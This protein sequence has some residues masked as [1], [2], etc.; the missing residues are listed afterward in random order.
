MDNGINS[1]KWMSIVVGILITVLF[2]WSFLVSESPLDLLYLSIGLLAIIWGFHIENGKFNETTTYFAAMFCVNAFQWLILI[3]VLFISRVYV[4]ND[5][6]TLIIAPVITIFLSYQIRRSDLK[7]IGNRQKTN[8]DV[9]LVDKTKAMLTDKLKFLLIF[10]GIMIMFICLASFF[11]SRSPSALFCSSI[12]MMMV[13]YGYYREDKK[14]NITVNY[15]LAMFSLLLFQWLILDY[16]TFIYPAYVSS[17]FFKAYAVNDGTFLF[18]FAF[19]FTMLFYIQIRE[20]GVK[21][22]KINWQGIF[23]GDKKIF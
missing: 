13:V 5:L 20:S 21:V 15:F 17:D 2:S 23:I 22:I 10:S 3:Y 8:K 4:T 9:I 1:I 7:Y 19:I 6:F 18:T 12:G 11:L 14:V 16:V